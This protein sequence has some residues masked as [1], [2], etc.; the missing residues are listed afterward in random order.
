MYKVL[1]LIIGFAQFASAQITV[2]DS[3]TKYPVSYATISFGNGQGIFADDA[4]D[5]ILLKNYIQI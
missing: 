2:K 5:F 4:G 1:L 3:I